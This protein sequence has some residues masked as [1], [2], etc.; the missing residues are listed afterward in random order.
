VCAVVAV[1]PVLIAVLG[2]GPQ[3]I[4]FVGGISL[5]ALVAGA[6][7]I[8]VVNIAAER[9][10]RFEFGSVTGEASAD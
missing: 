1:V 8:A 10:A 7:S 9:L 4:A 5:A 2:R 3:Q 6:G